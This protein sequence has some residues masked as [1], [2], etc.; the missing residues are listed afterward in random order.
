MSRRE[1][2]MVETTSGSRPCI[3]HLILVPSLIT[4]AV[5]LLRLVGEL[6]QWPPLF[7]S[8]AAGGGTAIVGI[9]WLPFI[10]GP[11]FALKLSVA[12]DKPKATWTA[13]LLVLLGAAVGFGGGMV[14]Y[15]APINLAKMLGGHLLIV[16]GVGLAFLAWC[17]LAKTLLAYGYAARIPVAIV[18]FFAM[19]FGWDTHYSA[20]PPGLQGLGGFWATYAFAGLLPQ[21]VLWIWVTVIVGALLGIMVNAIVRRG[22]PA[23]QAA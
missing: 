3:V 18:M 23:P 17:T 8:R 16:G 12:G 20:L 6:Q 9:S 22:K 7:F 10:F 13:L 5:T 4:L 1:V 14:A 21:L 2:F 15:S 19:R 11:Y